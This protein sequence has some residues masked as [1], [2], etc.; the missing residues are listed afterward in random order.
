MTSDGLLTAAQPH[1][2]AWLAMVDGFSSPI[3][4]NVANRDLQMPGAP[5]HYRLDVYQ[6]SDFY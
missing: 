3:G 5:R 4:P 6:R 1:D 2:A